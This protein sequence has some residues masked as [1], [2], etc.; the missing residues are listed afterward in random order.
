MNNLA[1]HILDLTSNGIDAQ[2]RSIH[3]LVELDQKGWMNC[4]ISDDGRGMSAEELRACRHPY[5]TSRKTRHIGLGL[6][7]IEQNS[8]AVGG[9]LEIE[10]RQ[11]HGTTISFSWNLTHPDVLPCG[12]LAS[13]FTDMLSWYEQQ[14]VCTLVSPATRINWDSEQIRAEISPLTLQQADV[15]NA[16][17][18]WLSSS[19]QDF[20]TDWNTFTI[21]IAELKN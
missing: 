20:Y 3:I 16:I 6:S 18:A 13:G 2:A 21:E 9:S 1:E 15:R 12:D 10:S 14:L 4:R 8:A 5:F 19:V 7:F 11:G 17:R